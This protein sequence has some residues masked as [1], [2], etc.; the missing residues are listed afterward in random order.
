M[1]NFYSTLHKHKYAI[2]NDVTTASLLAIESGI[3][4]FLTKNTDF[5]YKAKKTKKVLIFSNLKKKYVKIKTMLL[6]Q[7]KMENI[8]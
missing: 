3:P 5:N 7:S 1:S 6:G 2:G 8:P 4:F